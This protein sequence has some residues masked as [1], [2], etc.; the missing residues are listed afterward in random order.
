MNKEK[1]KYNKT[2]SILTKRINEI[3]SLFQDY[4]PGNNE[5]LSFNELKK[6]S[7]IMKQNR[8]LAERRELLLHQINRL[9]QGEDPDVI[10]LET[11]SK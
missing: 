6:E 2:I 11:L 4:D 10:L 3:E 7:T 5:P 8:D 9:E 1:T